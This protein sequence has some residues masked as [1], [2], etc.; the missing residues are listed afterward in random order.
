MSP[1]TVAD[2]AGEFDTIEDFEST[3][4]SLL[5][6]DSKV[7]K[8]L[9][10]RVFGNGKVEG[11]KESK[12]QEQALTD[13]KARIDELEGEL[14]EAKEKAPDAAKIQEAA[15]KKF[16]AKLK[17]EQTR[18]EAAESKLRKRTL[19]A[20]K[21]QFADE[22]VDHYGVFRKYA[23]KVA[24]AE[25]ESLFDLNDEL[26]L[27]GVKQW[28]DGA[29]GTY[30]AEKPEDAIKLLAE[31]YV[32]DVDPE[33]IGSNVERGA[34]VRGGGVGASGKAA[35]TRRIEEQKRATGHYNPI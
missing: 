8:E 17:A 1:R 21:R 23:E 11:K 25:V 18:R 13:A 29:Q 4:V 10:R 32:K 6:S 30:E 19:D 9:R 12:S 15:E 7:I 27:A 31:A 33:F 3:V 20:A 24:A 14:T 35:E 5:N 34:G 28:G 22:L 16:D 2:I 26:D